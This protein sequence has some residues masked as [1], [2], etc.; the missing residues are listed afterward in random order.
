MDTDG[1]DYIV[2]GTWNYYIARL[3]DD[4]ISLA[5]RPRPITLDKKFG[6]YGAGKTDDKPS[7]HQRNGIYY[8]SWS[9]FYAMSTNVYGPYTYKGSVITTNGPA[10]HCAVGVGH[11]AEQIEKLGKLLRIEAFKVC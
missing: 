10:H 4:M 11:I 9:S 5:E 1:K 7:L 6:P 8:L 3:N 2:F